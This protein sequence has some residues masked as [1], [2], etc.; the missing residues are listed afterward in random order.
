[1]EAA[2]GRPPKPDPVVYLN[3]PA[4]VQ[5][6][7][8]R[9][10]VVDLFC[11]IGGFTCGAAANGHSVVLAVDFDKPLLQCHL[12][13]HPTT[14]H[15]LLELG[16]DTDDD[17]IAQIQDAVSPGTPWHLHGSP[18]CTKL[19]TLQGAARSKA[20]RNY[21]EDTEEG[22][23]LVTWYLSL[24][25]RL[26]PTTWSFEQVA[27]PEI[28]GAL[29][30]MKTL[31][32]SLVDFVKRVHFK[33]YGVGQGRI[34]TIAGSPQLINALKHDPTLRC[35][36]PTIA[37]MLTPPTGAMLVQSKCGK[38]ADPTRTIRHADGSYTNDSIFHS[39]YRAISCISFTC[40][41]DGPGYWSRA[42]FTIIRK[43][44]P[45]ECAT[46]QSFPPE[47]KLP[48]LDALAY[49]G[50]GNAVPPKFVRRLMSA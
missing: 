1:L 38:R 31:Y 46:I 14:R 9:R 18:P 39:C 45:R 47:F 19:S 4:I 20:G 6:A 12:A 29:R 28:C 50:I 37:D 41:A 2:F 34:R 3:K 25:V 36:A 27:M 40:L 17:L 35:Q 10:L 7:A 30:M 48:A 32:P 49:T 43:F 24:V 13:N 16:P 15:L 8:G 26:R 44:T 22:M 5:P 23:R 11:G 21:D 33:D 42:D